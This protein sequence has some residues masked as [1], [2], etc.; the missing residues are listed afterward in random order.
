MSF[1]PGHVLGVGY[2][3]AHFEGYQ[4]GIWNHYQ[5]YESDDGALTSDLDASYVLALRKSA[6]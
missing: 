3:E 5:P 6:P 1:S 4:S 2:Y